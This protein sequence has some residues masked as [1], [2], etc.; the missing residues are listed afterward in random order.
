MAK[1]FGHNINIIKEA[2][3]TVSS[4]EKEVLK[5]SFGSL[6][7][8][9]AVEAFV[10]ILMEYV[11][12]AYSEN[13]DPFW[14]IYKRDT[15]VVLLWRLCLRHYL[16]ALTSYII[17]FM[18]EEE[19]NFLSLKRLTDREYIKN[20]YKNKK[21]KKELFNSNIIINLTDYIFAEAE[22]GTEKCLEYL[23]KEYSLDYVG[24][25]EACGHDIAIPPYPSHFCIKNYKDFKAGLDLA[26][27]DGQ[28]VF[29]IYLF[30]LYFE[31]FF[32]VLNRDFCDKEWCK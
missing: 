24:Y 8:D 7:K 32:S 3:N 11:K 21:E 17:C 2:E 19:H 5:P 1:L 30:D 4:T 9:A 25:M 31:K 27:E 15:S 22:M 20:Y 26:Y 23:K 13:R 6:R 10:D 28:D 14:D 18:P 16:T 12:Q 29:F